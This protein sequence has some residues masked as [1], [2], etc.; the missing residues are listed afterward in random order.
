MGDDMSTVSSE[1]DCCMLEWYSHEYCLSPV[2]GFQVTLSFSFV[3]EDPPG[4]IEF[5]LRHLVCGLMLPPSCFFLKV[6]CL[7]VVHIVQLCPNT[8]SKIVTYE[9][10]CVAHT[11][12]LNVS[13]FC[14]FYH[15]KRYVDWFSFRSRHFLLSRY[16]AHSNGNW[17]GRFHWVDIHSLC[18]PFF[19]C[20]VSL[21]DDLVSLSSGL[22]GFLPLFSHFCVKRAFLVEVI[23]SMCHTNPF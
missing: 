21:G 5:Y 14:Y 23:F 2:L 15:L 10:F 18:L 11:I 22:L 17:K 4:K 1:V 16:L 7:Y 8:V 20:Y 19:Q 9:V 6:L 3:L 12:P 13:L